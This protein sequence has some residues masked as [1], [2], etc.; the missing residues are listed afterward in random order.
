MF[1]KV[2]LDYVP[3]RSFAAGIEI[4]LKAEGEYYFNLVVLK[5]NKNQVNIH[6]QKE[7][8]DS[9]EQLKVLLDAEWP[10]VL[11]ING[12]GIIH[13][14][15]NASSTEQPTALLNKV[16]PN[17]N[18]TEFTVQTT[19]LNEQEVFV[20]VI[21]NAVLED[22]INTLK[23][24]GISEICNCVLGPFLINGIIPLLESKI[25]ETGII[26]A[27]NF[28][29]PLLNNQVTDLIVT[30][31]T[32][33][34]YTIGTNKVSGNSILAF[35]AAI[36]YFTNYTSSSIHSDFINQLTEEFKQKQKFLF[37]SKALI[38]ASFVILLINYLFFNHYWTS[39]TEMTSQLSTVESA[40]QRYELINAEYNS[41]KQ[42]LDQ[43]GLLENSRTS[44]YV[45]Q[46]AINLPNNI[47]WT[48]VNVFP[49]I[50]KNDTE[51]NYLM[52]FKTKT[53]SVSGTCKNSS[54]LNEWMKELKN[55]L[56]IQ[57]ITMQTYR[58]D[59][60][61]ENGIFTIELEIK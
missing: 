22:L 28:Q 46:L 55:S 12:R 17:A 54:D 4:I 6:L 27:G 35:S 58:Q 49:I 45:D 8:I 7:N 61:N 16:L 20:S 5:K 1:S 29:L 15:A 14:K 23:Q 31:T 51:E 60:M 43:N 2:K 34:N 24:K 56:W 26:T 38:A 41:K 32:S 11:L 40:L 57:N 18:A 25:I 37:R 30:E 53:I 19:K 13:K 36:S 21:R 52:S 59:N 44:Y 50:K 39:T 10:I 9:T 42:F 3:Q 48:D 47:Q 33:N